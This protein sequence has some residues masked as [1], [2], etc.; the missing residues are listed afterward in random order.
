M[1]E[2]VASARACVSTEAPRSAQSHTRAHACRQ[3]LYAHHPRGLARGL[4]RARLTHE[5]PT[6]P[7][8]SLRG[9]PRQGRAGSPPRPPAGPSAPHAPRVPASGPPRRAPR[10]SATLLTE[11]RTLR[12]PA[13]PQQPA[14]GGPPRP[15]PYTTPTHPPGR[16]R[17]APRCMRALLAPQTRRKKNAGSRAFR[18]IRNAINPKF[19]NAPHRDF[20]GTSS[21]GENAGRLRRWLN[22]GQTQTQTQTQTQKC[23]CSYST[24]ERASSGSETLSS[25]NAMSRRA[26]RVGARTSCDVFRVRVYINMHFDGSRGAPVRRG[27]GERVCPGRGGRGGGEED[28][29][30]EGA[31]ARA[32]TRGQASARIRPAR[33]RSAPGVACARGSLSR[34]LAP[35]AFPGAAW[36]QLR[37][38]LRR[39][40]SVAAGAFST[41]EGGRGPPPQAAAR[42][43]PAAMWA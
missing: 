34:A 38:Q 14:D 36:Q 10:P 31:R 17:G 24:L 37:W 33:P 12:D 8:L 25:P 5:T 41:K 42:R 29:G 4:A 22:F 32:G 1:R 23:L 16:T 27:G 43:S 7:Q 15:S 18:T 39:Q 6:P 26:P 21:R 20:G 35:C 28:G 9:R 19:K 2:G 11:G 30:E 40:L 3:S 13:G